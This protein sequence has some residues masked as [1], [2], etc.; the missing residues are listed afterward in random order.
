MR[1][2]KDA[3]AVCRPAPRAIIPSSTTKKPTINHLF[4]PPRVT[5]KNLSLFPR[6]PS[7]IRGAKPLLP[8]VRSY[9][10]LALYTL[11]FISHECLWYCHWDRYFFV[12][13]AN[14][15][16]FLTNIY[17]S[18]RRE[19]IIYF[20]FFKKKRTSTVT[21]Y[22]ASLQSLWGMSTGVTGRNSGCTRVGWLSRVLPIKITAARGL[23][24]PGL[25]EHDPE[26]HEK[27]A[28]P[29]LFSK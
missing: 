27:T 12:R 17:S 22:V 10:C 15:C 19:Q 26:V 7:W 18:G 21:F 25:S 13:Y 4:T 2:W 5:H 3:R 24:V 23:S 8:S 16:N 9:C 20:F 1:E 11:G 14:A 28:K 29:V 6:F